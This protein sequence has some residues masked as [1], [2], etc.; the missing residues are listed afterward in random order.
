MDESERA[1]VDQIIKDLTFTI[2]KP[3]RSAPFDEN[4][5]KPKTPTP[6]SKRRAS[7]SLSQ[8]VNTRYPTLKPFGNFS[9]GRRAK[10]KR[11][12]PAAVFA[13]PDSDEEEPSR[14]VF[15]PA[16]LT[17]S[18]NPPETPKPRRLAAAHSSKY[19]SSSRS[20]YQRSLLFSKRSPTA[21]KPEHSLD[22]TTSGK[23]IEP[24]PGL[25]PLQTLRRGQPSTSLSSSLAQLDAQGPPLNGHINHKRT[26]S[27]L[28]APSTLKQKPV[29]TTNRSPQLSEISLDSPGYWYFPTPFQSLPIARSITYPQPHE[30]GL[31]SISTHSLPAQSTASPMSADY[32]NPAS[33][34]ASAFG[35]SKSKLVAAAEKQ[36]AIVL[37]KAKKFN[38]APPPY[39]LLELVGKGS[40]G[41]VFKAYVSVG[42]A[43]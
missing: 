11:K 1:I 25:N 9:I 5:R 24:L 39:K 23:P 8:A 4:P 13:C 17:P 26:P 42:F 30:S 15:P 18:A 40:F 34:Q 19:S 29:S 32:L 2:S 27:E 28:A 7:G 33:A 22:R 43:T 35:T 6:A 10:V 12:P 31:F 36:Q 41:L 3:K 37:E 21:S 14:Y 38:V 20:P 16:I